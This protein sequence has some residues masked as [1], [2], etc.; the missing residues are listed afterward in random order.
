[1]QKRIV[2]TVISEREATETGSS[3]ITIFAN[4]LARDGIELV[5]EG[6]D[7]VNY[8]K[9]PVVLWAHDS[10]GHTESAGLPIGRTLGLE[11]TDGKLVADFEFLGDDPF[12]QRVK[13]AW[14]KGF[15]NAS[16]IAW[17][18][19]ETEETSKED[20]AAWRDVKSELLEWSLVA[21]PADPDA[22]RDVA[23]RRLQG[24]IL[25]DREK[26]VLDGDE[27]KA[28]IRSIVVDAVEARVKQSDP[29]PGEL[30]VAV[31]L[32]DLIRK[33]MRGEE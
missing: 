14:D 28:Y 18:P 3:R 11:K 1:M 20:K 12:A 6:L 7:T 10:T 5:L 32:I 16:S 4:A 26:L 33:E 27:M 24:G 25:E 30:A 21:V 31:G 23:Y 15:I 2:E 29:D 9:N 17:M 19:T 8:L 22:L 13:N